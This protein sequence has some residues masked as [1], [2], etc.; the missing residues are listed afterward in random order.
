MRIVFECYAI[1][2][3]LICT[4]LTLILA[5]GFT[6][7]YLEKVARKVINVSFLLYGPV[8]MTICLYG[9]TDIKALARI[10]TLHGISKNTN[11]VSLF[12]LFSCF[13]FSICASFTIAMESSLDVANSAFTNEGSIMFRLTAYYFQFQVKSR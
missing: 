7:Y 11:F 5:L 3:A 1:Y 13:I 8:L 2:S 6:D 9:F 12:V 4:L 10:C